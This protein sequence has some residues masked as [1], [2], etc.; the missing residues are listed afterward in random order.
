MQKPS[1]FTI[2][3]VVS[4]ALSGAACGDGSRDRTTRADSA[5]I[6]IV[7][8]YGPDRELSWR[9]EAVFSLGGTDSGP[10]AF[11]RLSQALVK[12]DSLGNIFVLD[13]KQV[14][15]FSANGTFLWAAG[16]EGGGPGE[17]QFPGALT[18]APNGL[19]SVFDFSKQ[20]LVRFDSRGTPLAQIPISVGFNGGNI[21]DTGRGVVLPIQHM[22]AEADVR[23]NRIVR[24]VDDSVSLVFSIPSAETKSITLKSCGMGFSGMPPIFSPNIRW[25][26]ASQRIALAW[27]AEYVISWFDSTGL[28]RILRRDI[29]PTTATEEHAIAD[30]GEGMKVR[31]SSGVLTCRSDEVVS[32]RGIAR[33][34]PVI[35]RLAISPEGALWVEPRHSFDSGPIDIFDPG[36]NYVGTLPEAAPFPTVF[37]P[38]EKIGV[39]ETDELDVPR[40]VV[41]QI[42]DLQVAN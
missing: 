2:V 14:K 24:V 30:L 6:E 17:M 22:D 28:Y 41:Y 40:L 1:L 25:A 34:I 31:T 37:L 5:G 27:N 36:G 10:E 21:Y 23:E 13:D 33:F 38:D 11:F 8:T 4:A 16:R 15:A 20:A 42:L 18:V 35:T 7:D 39:I 9:L 26:G 32:E 29:S 12:T 19:V 3:A